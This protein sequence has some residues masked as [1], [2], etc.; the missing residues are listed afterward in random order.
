MAVERITDRLNSR[1]ASADA[2][3]FGRVDNEI[4]VSTSTNGTKPKDLQ[5]EMN[6]EIE[7]MGW[8]IINGLAR[9]LR[10]IGQSSDFKDDKEFQKARTKTFKVMREKLPNFEIV[11]PYKKP[12]I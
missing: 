10:V 12:K 5:N 6:Q 8:V 9:T 7:D 3:A 2:F 1:K 4:Y 11:D